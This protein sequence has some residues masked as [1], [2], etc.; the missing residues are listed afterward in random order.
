[1]HRES[2]ILFDLPFGDAGVAKMPVPHPR[3]WAQIR[4]CGD[5]NC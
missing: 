1:M 5:R 3:R 4:V 2:G